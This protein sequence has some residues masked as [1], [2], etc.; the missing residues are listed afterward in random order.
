MILRRLLGRPEEISY[1]TKGEVAQKRAMPKGEITGDRFA[2]QKSE[3]EGRVRMIIIQ[4]FLEVREVIA[5]QVTFGSQV[6]AKR[7][8]NAG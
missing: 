8:P 3:R 5:I 1:T 6:K 4:I 7:S 2:T